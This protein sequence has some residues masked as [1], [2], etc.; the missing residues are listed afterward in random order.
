MRRRPLL[1]LALLS[2][3]GC[4][5][6][7]APATTPTKADAK[8]EAND[9]KA[10]PEPT[11]P[12][13]SGED[14]GECS[15]AEVQTLVQSLAQAEPSARPDIVARGLADA[16]QMPSY[17]VRYFELAQRM[18]P[19][20]PPIA[21]PAAHEYQSVL[22]RACPDSDRVLEMLETTAPGDRTTA[23]FDGCRLDRF[24]LVDRAAYLRR[25]PTSTMPFIAL[26]WLRDQ[27]I[28][29]EPARAVAQA[30]EL[31][32]RR[33]QGVVQPTPQLTIPAVSPSTSV[34]A[35]L[36]EG[37]RVYLSRDSLRTDDETLV[38]LEAGAFRTEDVDHHLVKMLYERLAAAAEATP[39]TPAKP[40]HEGEATL[41]VVADTEIPYGSLVNV[42][43]T[44]GRAGFTRYAFV[45]EGGVY[46]HGAIV[47]EPPKFGVL[48]EEE[49][50][51]PLVV[52]IDSG[53]FEL[54][55]QGQAEPTPQRLGVR[56]A[57]GNDAWDYEAL[58][59]RAREHVARHSGSPHSRSPLAM[60]SPDGD[61]PH[62]VVVRTLAALQG[63]TAGG[64]CILP[65]LVIASPGT[66]RYQAGP[67]DS[68]KQL[69]AL[70]A[71]MGES[72]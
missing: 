61:I 55:N 30:V 12:P 50:V 45:A 51:A 5:A 48:P 46:E 28:E 63:C 52:T 72:G 38:M 37:P 31:F 8:A 49:P 62:E 41:V 36:P 29:E 57:V 19:G 71:L 4:S 32:D 66:T 16:C 21:A 25:R 1:A 6:E 42:L 59:T 17:L 22:E 34:L 44:G 7:P 54:R 47:V 18:G 60:V 56:A 10:S 69:E 67:P 26:Q 23:I 70:E 27:G 53:G 64:T 43:Y 15:R 20:G 65:Q 33:E 58:A 39:A 3:V 68:T 2:L 9:A 14:D 35:A 24:G 40:G 13:P 11:A